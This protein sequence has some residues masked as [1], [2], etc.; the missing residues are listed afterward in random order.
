MRLGAQLLDKPWCGIRRRLSSMRV[1]STRGPACVYAR[2]GKQFS[3][4]FPRISITE[5]VNSGLALVDNR[6]KREKRAIWVGMDCGGLS[7]LGNLIP[8]VIQISYWL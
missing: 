1:R 4:L 6:G 3:P 7:I 5:G 2:D 8:Y